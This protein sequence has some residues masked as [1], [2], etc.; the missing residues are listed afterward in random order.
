MFSKTLPDG[1]AE[2]DDMI[3][4]DDESKVLITAPG[5]RTTSWGVGDFGGRDAGPFAHGM[6]G[7]PLIVNGERDGRTLLLLPLGMATIP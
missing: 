5:R 7:A 3:F 6:Y 2:G 4:V 1:G